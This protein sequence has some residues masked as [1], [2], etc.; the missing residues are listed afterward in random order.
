MRGSG[1]TEDGRATGKDAVAIP[2]AVQH[3]AASGARSHSGPPSTGVTI[4][5]D[6]GV[7]GRGT[8]GIAQN[9]ASSTQS[10]NGLREKIRP[11]PQVLAYDAPLSH[12][13]PSR[14]QH[15]LGPV[16]CSSRSAAS[17]GLGL[18]C[19]W[20][21]L[22]GD[23][24]T[25][26]ALNSS[27]LPSTPRAMSPDPLHKTVAG[28][29]SHQYRGVAKSQLKPATASSWNCSLSCWRFWP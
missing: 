24:T 21:V 2:T 4:T 29:S 3:N 6:G 14:C 26:D 16:C 20:W 25:S 17:F 9:D 18:V 13:L 15:V 22:H 27:L 19:G 8:L 7:A 23:W 1:G 11:S 10:R 5:M 28:I 12:M